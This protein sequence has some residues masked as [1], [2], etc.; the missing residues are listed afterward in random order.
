MTLGDALGIALQRLER[1]HADHRDVVAG[2]A[3][4]LEQ[5]AHFELDQVEQLRVVD[6]VAPC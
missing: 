5:L 1:R 3:V 4:G 2:E 6:R